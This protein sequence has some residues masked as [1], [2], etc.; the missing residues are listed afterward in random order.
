MAQRPGTH[1]VFAQDQFPAPARQLITVTPMPG[2]P[3]PSTTPSFTACGT[4]T[5]S[6]FFFF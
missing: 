6:I 3:A 1:A 2:D 4:Q 5:I